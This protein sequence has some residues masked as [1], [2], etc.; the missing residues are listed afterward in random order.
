MAGTLTVQNLQG[1]ASGA[2]ANKIIVPSGQTL[3]TSAGSVIPSSGQIKK[4]ITWKPVVSA[5][6][7][8]TEV[9]FSDLA[10]TTLSFTQGSTI[11][12]VGDLACR[13]DASSGWSLSFGRLEVDNIGIVFSSG[14]NGVN[15]VANIGNIS[16]TTSFTWT[17][18]A[19]G[20]ARL[21]GASYGG[22]TTVFGNSSQPSVKTQHETLVFME[23]AQ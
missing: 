4:I 21:K 20:T 18:S 6:I 8:G 22:N 12:V 14:Y 2:N 16:I 5:S 9:Q 13:N 23:I 11:A 19:T 10:T 1:P 15:G 3:D 17:L 7:T